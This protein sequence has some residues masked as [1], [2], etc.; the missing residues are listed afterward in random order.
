MSTKVTNEPPQGLRAG[1]LRSY[2]IIVD[3]DK[4]ERVETA[5]WRNLMYAICFLHSVVQER[6]KFGPLGWCI[7]Y[8]FN[9]GDLNACL[10]FL[11]KHLYSSQ[12]SWPTLQY[13]V[14]DVQYGGK[15]TDD[16]DRRLFGSYTTAWLSPFTLTPAFS[17]NPS[18][19]INR[20]PNDFQYSIPDSPEVRNLWTKE[21]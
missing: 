1:L 7:P 8:E 17:F 3:Q 18:S 11:E 12:L 5:Q 10:T 4:L 14:S 6:R 9:D 16:L 13:M 19:P 15:I 2:T 21:K 20:I